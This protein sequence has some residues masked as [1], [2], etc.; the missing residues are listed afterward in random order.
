MAVVWGGGHE[1]S[2]PW[3]GGQNLAAPTCPGQPPLR[4][5]SHGCS[6][7]APAHHGQAPSAPPTPATHPSAVRGGGG[8]TP[9]PFVPREGRNG[10]PH[11]RRVPSTTFLPSSAHAGSADRAPRSRSVPLAAGLTTGARPRARPG[12][13]GAGVGDGRQGHAGN[14]FCAYWIQGQRCAVQAALR[15]AGQAAGALAASSR[16]T[17]RRSRSPCYSSPFPFSLACAAA[18]AT[19]A[20]RACA[21]P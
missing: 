13:A 14:V 9:P 4:P 21:R 7:A 15:A 8:C 17:T 3:R 10:S 1:R 11:G 5:R 18:P 16:G 2:R 19:A 6:T 20:A 12:S